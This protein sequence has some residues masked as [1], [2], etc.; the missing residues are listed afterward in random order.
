MIARLQSRTHAAGFENIEAIVGGIGEGKLPP[1]VR[2][3]VAFLVTVLGE[4]RRKSGALRE[5]HDALREGG[6][7]SVTEVLPDPHYLRLARVRRLA[8]DADFREQRLFAGPLSYTV[9]FVKDARLQ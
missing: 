3:D 9:N 5:L 7:L 1:E 4:V 8:H 6:I 2:F